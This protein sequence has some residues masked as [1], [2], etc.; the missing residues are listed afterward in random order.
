MNRHF[1]F[2]ILLLVSPMAG[3]SVFNSLDT[4]TSVRSLSLTN[5]ASAVSTSILNSN[6][7]VL[8]CEGKSFGGQFFAYPAD[9]TGHQLHYTS[10]TARG[11]V[12]TVVTVM[13]FGRFSDSATGETFS[14]RDMVFR[15]GY[16]SIWSGHLSWGI[17]AG[18]IH[19]VIQQY[20]SSGLFVNTGI[21]SRFLDDRLGVGISAENMGKMLS[22][23]AGRREP[24]EGQIRYSCF[25]QPLH[26]PATLSVDYLNV[27]SGQPLII[28]AAEFNLN[29]GFALWISASSEK[30]SLAWGDVFRTLTA[31]IAG[32]VRLP[33]G[34]YVFDVGF[35]NLGSAG[36]VWGF[37]IGKQRN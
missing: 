8:D 28:T 34:N 35:Q 5:G 30:N 25:Y 31:G 27:N 18:G 23:Y 17:S 2:T 10:K 7:A 9:I 29:S 36:S 37:G 19:S 6:P 12:S 15:V 32:G 20:R 1:L 4:P 11:V 33:I 24:M 22:T 13:D 21:R 14:A 3:Q 16:K 26:L